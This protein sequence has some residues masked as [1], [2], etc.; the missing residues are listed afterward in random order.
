MNTDFDILIVGGGLVGG[1]LA[2]ALSHSSLRIGLVEAQTDAERQASPAGLRA[3]ALSRGT[4]QSLEQMGVWKAVASAAM[5]I[6]HIHVSDRGHFGKTRLHASEADV[7]ALGHVVVARVLE[8]AIQERVATAANLT[9]LCPARI[10]GLKS[11]PERML[12]SLKQDGESLNVAARLCV[13][14][15]GGQSTVRSLL[16]IE[17]EIRDYG[18]T[19]IV[20]EVRTE[21][22]TDGTAYERFTTSGPLAFLPLE[23]HKSSVVW[24]L[25]SEDAENLLQSG[26]QEFI[27]SLQQA[28]GH[29]LG[30]L[31]LASRPQGHPLKLIKAG[32]MTDQRVILI[33]NAM[34]QIHPVAG[35]GFNLGLRDAAVLAE[36][37]E[38]Q[39]RLGGDPGDSDFLERYATARRKDLERVIRFTDGLVRVFSNESTPLSLAR[40]AALIAMDRIPAAKRLL[41][42]HAMGY[43]T[44]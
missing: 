8:N 38:T 33:G 30:H 3:L 27:A 28:F 44:R 41:C 6:R 26:E 15:D 12:V 4:A 29:W 43:G 20:T 25:S 32:S 21:K 9:R 40:N 35:Q 2:L 5:P 16:G 7:D 14:A 42:H 13:A 1:S 39:V 31:T 37:I 11:G 22:P 10:L 19:A 24:T 36:R 23:R 17:Q 34:H 18:Q